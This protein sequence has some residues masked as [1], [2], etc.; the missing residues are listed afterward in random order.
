MNNSLII[1]A[2]IY[3]IILNILGFVTMGIDKKRAINRGWRIPERTLL[4]I[5]FIGGAL[6]SFLG[7]YIFRHKTRHVKFR[8]LLTLALLLWCLTPLR[9]SYEF[10]KKL[11]TPP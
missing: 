1:L 10:L 2:I 5:A 4:L 3:F 7:M 11:L 8:I 6:G 9:N